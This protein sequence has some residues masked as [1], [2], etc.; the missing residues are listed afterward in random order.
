ML[1]PPYSQYRARQSF[2]LF[3]WTLARLI[4]EGWKVVARKS[5]RESGRNEERKSEKQEGEKKGN[6]SARSR[7]SRVPVHTYKR[8]NRNH[9]PSSHTL[10]SKPA[11]NR[12]IK[13][14]RTNW[15]AGLTEFK[16]GGL[17]V[18]SS[19]VGIRTLKRVRF[20]SK[21][22]LANRTFL[23]NVLHPGNFEFCACQS[24]IYHYMWL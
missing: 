10:N 13:L 6:R 7:V 16:R 24:W 15:T 4:A 17:D 2:W 23:I 5:G 21:L 9:Q 22:V 14:H 8:A 19:I 18:V 20:I 3:Q 1:R 11:A 12:L